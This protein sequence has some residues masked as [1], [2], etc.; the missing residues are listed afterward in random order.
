MTDSSQ[1]L[2][3]PYAAGLLGYAGRAVSPECLQAALDRAPWRGQITDQHVT[4]FGGVVALGSATI[5]RQE[6]VTIAI[7][8]RIDNLSALAPQVD[9]PSDHEGAILASAYRTFGDEFARKL[10]GDFSLIL[11]DEQRQAVLATRDW[12]GARPLYWGDYQGATAFGSEVKQV[13]ALLGRAFEIDETILSLYE[14]RDTMPQ[15]ATFAAGVKAV[16]PSGQVCVRDGEPTRAW[17]CPLR[18]EPIEI[19]AA[20]AVI[21]TRRL[22][23]Q[24][25]A[26]RTVGATSLGALVS[27]GMDSTSVAATASLLAERHGGPPVRHA[28]TLS[29]PGFPECDET[30]LARL[31]AERWQITSVP[32]VVDPARIA[33]GRRDEIALHDG[34]PFPS[35]GQPT[36]YPRAAAHGTDV[37]LTGQMADDSLEQRGNELLLSL[38]RGKWRDA[39]LVSRFYARHRPHLGLRIWARAA[40]RRLRGERA[41]RLFENRIEGY[42]GRLPLELGERAAMQWGIRAEAPFADE[43]LTRFLAGIPAGV[44]TDLH[45]RRTKAVLRGA[46]DGLLPP[47]VRLRNGK[48]M[49]DA[50]LAAA[51]ESDETPIWP[52]AARAY[53]SS[54]REL[55]TP[56]AL[57]GAE[58]PLAARAKAIDAGG[59]ARL[60]MGEPVSVSPQIARSGV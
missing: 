30:E 28:Y 48:S 17:R 31:V 8:G 58:D 41:E 18:I 22:L 57:S 20:E 45:A 51:Y 6:Q 2:R 11:L 24:A 53:V 12:I 49:F 42:M 7:H 9:A 36:L 19:S 37:L 34:P 26:R 1:M 38:M 32:V 21:E 44:R 40:R 13:L 39:F 27:G 4:P 10:I 50:V 3:R 54:F 56:D 47:E 16:L 15:D 35:I 5:H 46:M 23:E 29:Y 43:E 59:Q 33:V 25:V 55:H 14:S 52:V 60:V